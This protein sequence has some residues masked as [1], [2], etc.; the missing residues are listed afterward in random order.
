MTKGIL[1]RYVSNLS[2]LIG[3]ENQQKILGNK[4]V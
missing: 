1:I 4:F 2:N 3:D